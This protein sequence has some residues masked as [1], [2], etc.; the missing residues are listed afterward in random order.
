MKR[1]TLIKSTVISF[2]GY[3]LLVILLSFYSHGV[4]WNKTPSMFDKFLV[5]LLKGLTFIPVGLFINS[6][7]YTILILGL[8]FLILKLKAKT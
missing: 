2:L 6:L 5:S 7:L 1:S 8:I 3:W 4:T